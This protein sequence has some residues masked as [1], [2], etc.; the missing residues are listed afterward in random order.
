MYLYTQK[1][2]LYTLICIYIHAM[3][4]YT[5]IC[6]YIYIACMYI[7]KTM[8]IHTCYVFT[9]LS[10]NGMVDTIALLAS[11]QMIAQRDCSIVNHIDDGL[12]R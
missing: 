12:H 9:H 10:S 5:H 2:F 6:V 3:Y 1:V 7:H 8:Y 11:K 4:T